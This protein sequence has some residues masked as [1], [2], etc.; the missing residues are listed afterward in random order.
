MSMVPQTGDPVAEARYIVFVETVPPR[1]WVEPIVAAW[2]GG[3]WHVEHGRSVYGW[4]GPLPVLKTGFFTG[5]PAQSVLDETFAK[6]AQE[7]DL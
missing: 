4:I 5:S 1:G 3:R 6:R 2:H 7:Y